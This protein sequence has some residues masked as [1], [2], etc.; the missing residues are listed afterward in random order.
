VLFPGWWIEITAK[1][2]EV[3]VA[4][5]KGFI[6][7]FDREHAREVLEKDDVLLLTQGMERYARGQVQ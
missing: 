4:D 6:Q 7:S 2:P 1:S 5:P 3:Y